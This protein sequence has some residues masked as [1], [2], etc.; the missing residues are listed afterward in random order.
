MRNGRG[1]CRSVQRSETLLRDWQACMADDLAGAYV[2]CHLVAFGIMAI[3]GMVLDKA[4]TL[5]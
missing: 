4:N 2:G 3:E 1:V 5:S